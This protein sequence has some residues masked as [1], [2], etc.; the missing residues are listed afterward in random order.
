MLTLSV[1]GKDKEEAINLLSEAVK[2]T[3]TELKILIDDPSQGAELQKYLESEGFGKIIPED[4]DG[5]LYLTA[6]KIPPEPAKPSVSSEPRI[7]AAVN[8]ELQG[9]GVVISSECRKHERGFLERVIASLPDT[10]NKPEVLCLMN[11]A[12]KLA[13]YNSPSCDILKK[14]EAEGV[15]V[16]ISK[17][18]ADRLGI[19][20]A[21]GAGMLVS[22]SEILEAVSCCEK[23]LS[24]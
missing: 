19:T 5:T 12:V 6:S 3:E 7:R 14:L 17:S 23:L 15:R 4:D 1:S 21:L 2:G 16:L 10:K 20:E 9:Y 8:T 11:G 13:E 22:L 24:L 18:C